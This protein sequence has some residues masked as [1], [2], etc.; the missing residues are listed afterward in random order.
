M[1]KQHRK[2]CY[3]V[4]FN[5]TPL[6]RIAVDMFRMGTGLQVKTHVDEREARARLRQKGIPA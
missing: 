1:L 4:F 6:M 2:E 3:L 5:V